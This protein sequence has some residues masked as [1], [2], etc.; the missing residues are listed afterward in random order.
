MTVH[1]AKGLEFPH[2]FL[3]GMNEGKS[4]SRKVRTLP[5]MEERRL[6]FVA[7]TRVE[8]TLCLTEAEGMDDSPRYS[9]RFILDIDPELIAYTEPPREGLIADAR[10]MIAVRDRYLSDGAVMPRLEVG[11]RVRHSAFGSGTI[12]DVDT[13]HS[14]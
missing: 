3:C 5:G 9:S 7:V 13:D 1:S 6:A 4:P 11:Q 8:Q 14:A 10:A 2:V 12:V